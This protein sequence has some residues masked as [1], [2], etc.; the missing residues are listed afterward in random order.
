MRGTVAEPSR[1]RRGAVL[2]V[3]AGDKT[4]VGGND[5]EIFTSPRTVGARAAAPRATEPLP[6]DM[7]TTCPWTCPRVGHSI[8]DA[9][10]MTTLK[11]LST[12]FDLPCPPSLTPPAAH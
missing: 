8:D 9:D 4:F 10:P 7:C 5:Y 11:K 1:N 2:C 3:P 12:L 6:P